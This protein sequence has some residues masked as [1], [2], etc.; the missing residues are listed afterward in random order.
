M[1]KSLLSKL[2]GT[3]NC[4]S[5]LQLLV[6]KFHKLQTAKDSVEAFVGPPGGAAVVIMVSKLQG[7]TMYIQLGQPCSYRNTNIGKVRGTF[8]GGQNHTGMKFRP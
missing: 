1:E 6:E 8:L 4:S 3:N 2:S 5:D 7:D